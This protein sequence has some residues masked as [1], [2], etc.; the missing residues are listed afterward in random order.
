MSPPVLFSERAL[1][2]HSNALE[3][4]CFGLPVGYFSVLKPQYFGSMQ[5]LRRRI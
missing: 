1:S 5:K 2:E 4:E 3:G